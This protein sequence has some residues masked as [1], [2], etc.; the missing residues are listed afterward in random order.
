MEQ[1]QV[2]EDLGKRILRAARMAVAIHCLTYREWSTDYGRRPKTGRA[3]SGEVMDDL[4][5]K[6]TAMPS[7]WTLAGDDPA[8]SFFD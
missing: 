3:E 5:T 4:S 7:P 6:E 2:P 8:G 1:L